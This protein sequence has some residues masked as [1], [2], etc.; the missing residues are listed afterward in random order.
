MLR[1]IDRLC[2]NGISRHSDLI[3]PI[4]F[5]IL[6]GCGTRITETLHIE[7]NDVDLK[8]GTLILRHTKDAKERIIPI[9]ASLIEKCRL[10]ATKCQVF[11]S[12]N[13]T[14]WFF[15]NIH[16]VPYSSN[17]AYN[18]FRKTLS[19][20]G[21]SHGGKGKGP[22]LHDLRHTYA[23]RILNRWV[24]AGNNLTT[25]LPYLAIYMGHEGMKASQRYLR[26]TTTMFPEI[27]RTVEKKYGWIIPE[28]NYE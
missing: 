27:V 10:Y 28:V 17:T 22:R 16:G 11:R 23:V 2:E 7:K 12:F 14:P 26:L 18:L 13:S 4:V 21:I 6:I 8:N 9:A 15:P 3:F 20:A 25:A 24:Q 19:A 1:A 5:R